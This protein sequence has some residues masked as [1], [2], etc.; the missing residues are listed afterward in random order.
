MIALRT[1]DARTS[2]LIRC[3][4]PS[5]RDSFRPRLAT[6]TRRL[7]TSARTLRL[8]VQAQARRGSRAASKATPF[9]RKPTARPSLAT[10]SV[11]RSGGQ[12]CRT[13]P[14]L[15]PGSR[16]RP[17]SRSAADP[18]DLFGRRLRAYRSCAVHDIC[19][20]RL[21]SYDA[22]HEPPLPLHHRGRAD[23]RTEKVP[24][25]ME[26][27]RRLGALQLPDGTQ[28]MRSAQLQHGNAAMASS[29]CSTRT[30]SS[31]RPRPLRVALLSG[32]GTA[33]GSA[34]SSSS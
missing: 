27:E 13:P 16:L 22:W 26:N 20:I 5:S 14:T 1:G 15:P 8:P 25:R 23:E 7:P 24:R 34:S 2:N 12:C 18:L 9:D 31:P 19:G 32:S 11:G 17:R 21:H 29:T 4:A 6:P 33:S 28:C 3:T 30:P 10:A